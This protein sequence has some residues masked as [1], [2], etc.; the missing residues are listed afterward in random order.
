MTPLLRLYAF[1][2]FCSTLASFYVAEVPVA[3]GRISLENL[4]TEY[5]IHESITLHAPGR[6][7]KSLDAK[8]EVG[9]AMTR[10][11]TMKYIYWR[12]FLDD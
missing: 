1:L 2:S 9:C 8:I 12:H 3:E 11:V 7:K 6:A 5:E 10:G 4:L